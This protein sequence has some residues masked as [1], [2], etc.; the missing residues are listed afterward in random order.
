MNT[1]PSIK[2]Y[3]RWLSTAGVVIAVLLGGCDG[4]GFVSPEGDVT[5]QIQGT[6]RDAVSNAP[7]MNARVSVA[8]TEGYV[9]KDLTNVRTDA[10][11]RYALTYRLMSVATERQFRDNCTIWHK[12]NTTGVWVRAVSDGSGVWADSGEDGAPALR[13]TDA[14]QT[15][16]LRLRVTP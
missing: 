1:F 2:R 7:I 15:I 10:E 4:V 12:G 3:H 14:L 8:V 9:G 6:V 11:G 13:C 16:D 5:L